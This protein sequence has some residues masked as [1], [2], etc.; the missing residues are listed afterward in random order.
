M[1]IPDAIVNKACDAATG[2][3][4][5]WTRAMRILEPYISADEVDEFLLSNNIE[6][7]NSCEWFVES[8]ELIPDGSDDPDGLCENCRGTGKNDD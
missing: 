6:K 2:Y 3:A 7:C 8:S 4:D 5:G 1:N